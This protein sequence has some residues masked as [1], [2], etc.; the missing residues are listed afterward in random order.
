MKIFYT[1][2][3]ILCVCSSNLFSQEMSSQSVAKILDETGVIIPNSTG[4][5]NTAGYQM[6]YGKNNEPVFKKINSPNNTESFTWGSVGTGRNGTSS[7]VYALAADG[8][9][10]IYIGGDFTR[11]SDISANCIAK[12]NGTAW[13]TLQIGASNG[14]SGIV[15]AIAITGND[16]YVGGNFTYLGDGITSA[17]YIAK[18]TTTTS[19]WST[20][21]AGIGTNGLNNYVSAITI[22]GEYA[23]V[24]GNFTMLGDGITSAKYIAAWN[25]SFSGGWLRLTSGASNGLNNSVYSI[26]ANGTDIYV[27]GAFT[28]LGDGTTSANH[29]ARWNIASFSWS[30]LTIGGSNGVNGNVNAIALINSNVYVGGAF[31]LLGDGTTTANYIALWNSSSSTWST[32]TSGASNGVNGAVT[33]ITISTPNVYVGGAFTLLGDGSTS[34]NHLASWNNSSGIW[35]TITSGASNGVN[36]NINVLAMNGSTLYAGGIFSLLGDGTTSANNIANWNG[37]GWSVLGSG[38]NGVNTTVSAIAVSGNDVYIGGNF[39]RL[40]DGTSAKYIAKWN[41]TT[42]SWSTLTCDAS[43]GVNDYVRAITTNGTDVYVG[44]DFS[45][46]GNGTTSAKHIAKWNAATSTWSTLSCGV[47]DGVNNYVQTIAISGSDVYVG[48]GF[49]LLGDGITSAKYIAKWNSNTSTWSTLPSGASNGLSD[50]PYIIAINGSDVYIGGEFLFLGDG[51][52]SANHLAKWNSATSTWS[53][54]TSGASNGVNDLVFAI[55]INGND[56]YI[57]GRFIVLGNGVTS[58]KCIAKWNSATST[59]STLPSGASN[60]VNSTVLTIESSGSDIYIGG[61]FTSLG[62]GTTFVNHMAKWNGSS[63]SAIGNGANSYIRAMKVSPSD[64]KMY[65]GGN[66]TVLND[67]VG[68]YFVGTFTDSDNPLSVEGNIA[69]LPAEYTLQQNYPNPFN[70]STVIRYSLPFDSKVSIKIYNIVGQEIKVLKNEI[71][72]AG[73]DEVKFNTSGLST[74]VY[75]YRL[76]AESLDGKQ[77]YSSVKKMIFLK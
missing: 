5:Y 30:T 35:S 34:A 10:N 39:T 53:T 9:G 19:T 13:S 7:G 49:T 28:L 75:F 32:L 44:G 56:V 45:M 50:Y 40:G 69:A 77:K 48:G 2:L 74:G 38:N 73:I 33:S 12:W 51:I 67:A 23:Y 14:V 47:S 11:V 31:I 46:L 8:G 24:G 71:I 29:I 43:N 3:I 37:S 76:N 4:S 36:N 21:L 66:F 60:G 18:W 42:R 70:P 27:G 55:A 61:A 41:I 57:G 52:T 65:V 54:L 68:A 25:T 6:T 17:S 64:K 58:A 26:A 62:N 59:W 22:N 1:S 72:S 16:V 15:Y 20:L 63:W